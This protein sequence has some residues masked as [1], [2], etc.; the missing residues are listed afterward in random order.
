MNSESCGDFS[1][2][3]DTLLSRTHVKLLNQEIKN[4]SRQQLQQQITAWET[5]LEKLGRL[6]TQ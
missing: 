1:L 3:R 4:E 6:N 5:L 2:S